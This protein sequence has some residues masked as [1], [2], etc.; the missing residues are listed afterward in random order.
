MKQSYDL[1]IIGAG[2]IGCSTA[3]HLARRGMKNILVVDKGT[4]SGGATGRCGGG[5]R[6]QW[7]AEM[8]I[9]LA[10]DSRKEFETMQDELGW[11]I[12]YRQGGYLIL[13]V[14]EEEAAR[15]QDNVNVQRS[16]GLDVELL[17]PRGAREIVPQLDT[18]KILAATYC[19]SDGSA[20]PFR[21]THAYA[22]AARQLGADV[23][24]CNEVTGIERS[25]GRVT[26]VQTRQGKVST[27]R[28]L[29]AAGG[30]A[31]VVASRAGID[32]PVNPHR[33][34]ILVTEPLERFFHTMIISFDYNI[35]V[36]QAVCG[37]VMGGYGDSAYPYGLETGSS[38]DFLQ[39]MAR[40]LVEL[41]P[42]LAPVR[43]VRQWSGLYCLSPDSQPILGP[44]D[45]LEGYYQ[46]VG[47][48]GHG[49][50]IAPAV[51]HILA[52]LITDG[53]TSFPLNELTLDRFADR[54][55]LKA[56]QSVV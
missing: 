38:L 3:Y 13:A 10:I 29:N 4:I 27:P 8:N 41:L 9:R 11:D 45:G 55:V 17:D 47:F 39:G 23:S 31:G 35:Y 25:A 5:I 46:A 52:D 21:V 53:E 51:A 30:Y 22:D 2:V 43:V 54:S 48:S 28:V 20:S 44:A 36:R 1:V 49:F 33:R 12:E 42:C 34:E 19:P 15:F 6:Q 18:S 37:A 24:I 32:L 56:E 7:G 14:T 40:K 50:M 26:A 16:M